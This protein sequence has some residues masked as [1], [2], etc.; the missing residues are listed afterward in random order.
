M[1]KWFYQYFLLNNIITKKNEYL[2]MTGKYILTHDLGTSG[3]KTALF[4]TQLKFINQVKS[5]YPLFYPKLGWAEQKAEDF[6]NSV[7]KNTKQLLQEN[8]IK[9]EEI[10]AMVITCQMNCTIP[11]DED[12][13]PL[14]NVISWLDTRASKIITAD[15]V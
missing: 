10:L 2:K 5:A 6:W 9:P 7:V 13:N 1:V 4:D 11:I 12:G 3:N 8:N 14:M 15:E